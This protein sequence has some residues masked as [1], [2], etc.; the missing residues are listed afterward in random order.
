MR[1][2]SKMENTYKNNKSFKA[3]NKKGSPLLIEWI[4]TPI[5]K[6]LAVCDE[7]YLY[8]LEFSDRK[9][10]QNG[11][12]RLYKKYNR[13]I[14]LG[15][16]SITKRIE[17]ELKLYFAKSLKEFT[18]PFLFTGTKYQKKIWFNLTKIPS[19]ETRSYSELAADIG[20]GETRSYSELA[21]D[22][23]NEKASRAVANS[24]A[25]NILA[26]I[27]PCHRVIMQSGFIGGYSGGA[28]RKKW[29]LN[30]ERLLL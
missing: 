10:I 27:I 4:S 12:D 16:T 8:M 18:T 1:N 14:I 21:A 6:M 2:F 9:N 24:N 30:H 23:G 19:G 13:H 11:F 15:R 25:K 7:N 17:K 3:I 28:E 26:L 5:G 20:N 22:I 29:L